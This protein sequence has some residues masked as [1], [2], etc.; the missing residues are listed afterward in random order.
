[1]KNSKIKSLQGAGTW[2]DMFKFEVTFENG[3]TGTV[4]SKSQEPPYKIGDSKYYEITPSGRGFK[5]KMLK[6][7]EPTQQSGGYQGGGRRDTN[8]DI[9][10]S[11]ALKASIEYNNAN[12]SDAGIDIILDTAQI[13]EHYL[14]TGSKKVTTTPTAEPSQTSQCSD[15]DDLPF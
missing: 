7:P 8:Q 2:N 14:M 4:F 15:G 3:D 9:A 6:D 5:V 12:K 1:M 13:F 10:R 11:V